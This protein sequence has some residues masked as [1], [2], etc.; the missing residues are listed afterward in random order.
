MKHTFLSLVMIKVQAL[1]VGMA[2]AS[3][4]PE[5]LRH[6]ALVEQLEETMVRRE[7]YKT[8]VRIDKY[9]DDFNR[10]YE[11]QDTVLD[12]IQQ[13]IQRVRSEEDV[14]EY[15]QA[16]ENTEKTSIDDERTLRHLQYIKSKISVDPVEV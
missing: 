10:L 3:S 15:M 13:E 9:E 2:F 4:L 11:M 6:M 1:I 16:I 7:Q 12:W 14:S 8:M 5:L